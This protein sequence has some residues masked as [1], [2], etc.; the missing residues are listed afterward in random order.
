[1]FTVFSKAG[2]G[3]CRKAKDLLE[4]KT[5]E[6]SE[7]SCEDIADLR[8][9]LGPFASKGIE[10]FPAIFDASGKY[11]GGYVHLRDRVDEPILAPTMQRYSAFPVEHPDIYEL[12]KKALASFWTA[13]EITLTKDAADFQELTRDEQHFIK[14]VLGFFAGSDGVVNENLD[15]NFY[16]EIQ[17][18]DSR[19]FLA[20]QAFNEA[21]HSRTYGMLIDSLVKDAEERD[22][23]FGAIEKVPAVARKAEWAMKWMDPGKNGFAER[24]LGFMC[25][26]GILFSGSFCAI[27][28]VKQAHP[29]KMPGLSLSNQFISRDEALHCQHAALVYS[30]LRHKLSE[31]RVHEIFKGAVD[32]EKAFILEA[33][34]CTLIGMNPRLMS[35]Y[36]EFVADSLLADIGYS[37]AY[38]T[39][40]P[41][42]WMEAIS[43]DGKTN[44]FESR[45]SEYSR[46]GVMTSVDSSVFDLDLDF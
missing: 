27:F 2:C 34:P 10:S 36:V 23:L 17:A 11:V 6:Y 22:I 13:D 46:A 24:L 16:Q 31:T 43:L 7:T 18:A 44:F 26:E 45:V 37:A 30:K 12:Y 41:F 9:R 1:M 29:G 4:A 32:A 40:N 5:L 21:E 38:G 14:H 3:W 28:W 42:S 39:K 35:E 20:Y 15:T 33:V 25:V 8:T 19:Q